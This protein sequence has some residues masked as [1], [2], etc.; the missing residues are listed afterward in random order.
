[1]GRV[2]A[3]D[4][5]T[6]G[7]RLA[8]DATAS[9]PA[10]WPRRTP[11]TGEMPLRCRPGPSPSPR[12]FTTRLS[13][14]L[15]AFRAGNFDDP[16]PEP[17]LAREPNHPA[18]AAGEQEADRPGLPR[19]R[20]DE[21]PLPLP[22]GVRTP[23]TPQPGPYADQRLAVHEPLAILS[24]CLRKE[25][26]ILDHALIFLAHVAHT[27]ARPGHMQRQLNLVPRSGAPSG[28]PETTAGGAHTRPSA[29][30]EHQPLCG[31]L[32]SILH[33]TIRRHAARRRSLRPS[34]ARQ[35]LGSSTQVVFPA[36]QLYMRML[37]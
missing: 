22:A 21:L 30:A 29:A 27:A 7:G 25:Q 6:F 26:R 32:S 18:A 1:M 19:I 37:S 3:R 31:Q 20:R 12:S 13:Q 16:S 36:Q 11:A 5:T 35:V 24:L 34:G 8:R 9:R 33:A 10:P 15:I 4:H 14:F 23:Q 2:S 17:V 28:L